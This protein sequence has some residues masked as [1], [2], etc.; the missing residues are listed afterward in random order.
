MKEP[1]TEPIYGSGNGL[2]ES[3]FVKLAP[4]LLF[5]AAI[6]LMVLIFQVNKTKYAVKETAA[7]TRVSNCVI[8]KVANPPTTQED[9][10][11]CY[12]QVEKDSHIPL[13]R[14]DFQTN[15][16]NPKDDE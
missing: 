6:M 2:L 16:E 13:E 9:V 5:V 1:T 8:A 12:T 11:K 10:E 3:I 14:F 15:N 4:I 7:Y